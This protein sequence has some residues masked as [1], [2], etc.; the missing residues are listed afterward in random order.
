MYLKLASTGRNIEAGME[1]IGFKVCDEKGIVA[2]H[3]KVVL[4]TAPEGVFD[5]RTLGRVPVY[6]IDITARPAATPSPQ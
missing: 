2:D 5:L 6:S 1:T 4:I 3:T